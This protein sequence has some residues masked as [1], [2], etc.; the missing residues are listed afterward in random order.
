MEQKACCPCCEKH[1]LQI[2]TAMH[3]MPQ[4]SRIDAL[5]GFFK[6]LGDPTRIKMMYV[7]AQGEVCVQDIA[8]ALGMTKSAISHQLSGLKENGIVK[9]RREG[10]NVYYSIDDDHVQ[11]VLDIAMTH[12]QHKHG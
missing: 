3:N 5:S 2:D 8:A 1:S 10:K 4:Q 11:A 12:V 7:M 6:V 9:S